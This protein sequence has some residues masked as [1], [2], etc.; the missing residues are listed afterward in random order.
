M[1]VAN[2]LEGIELSQ[3][4]TDGTLINTAEHLQS[5][6]LD[7]GKMI[8]NV[9][10][11]MKS[12]LT[13]RNAKTLAKLSAPIVT[14]GIGTLL[15]KLIAWSY[16]NT[17]SL[18]IT[19]LGQ[20]TTITQIAPI[21]KRTSSS[22]STEKPKATPAAE[23][24]CI[25]TVPGTTQAEY[26]DFVSSL[27]DGGTGLRINYPTIDWQ[28]YG[29]R[30]TPAQAL[31]VSKHPVVRSIYIDSFIEETGS[32]DSYHVLGKRNERRADETENLSYDQQPSS[33]D[34]LRLLSQGYQN[35]LER[36]QTKPPP[37]IPPYLLS[38]EAGQ[39][40]TIF[41]VGAG[42][43]PTHPVRCCKTRMLLFPFQN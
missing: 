18:T 28:V 27:P 11:L 20:S 38:P 36:L 19:P 31:D 9:G 43:N 15:K 22:T 8:N 29:S 4:D 10:P 33:P 3:L 39:G 24:Y 37:P 30:L 21:P 14:G 26:E 2:G 42:I 41:V 13:I 5:D 25:N 40:I 12:K 7:F 35:V 17:Y 23:L 34:H 1:D 16:A 32:G 6:T